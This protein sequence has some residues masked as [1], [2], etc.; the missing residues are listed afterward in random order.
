MD[1]NKF[2]NSARKKA[3]HFLRDNEMLDRLLSDS[4]AKMEQ[5]N[6]GSTSPEKLLSYL[7]VL[8]RMIR[9]YANGSYKVIPW[10]SIVVLVAAVVYFVMP[11]DLIPDF[12]PVAGFVDDLGVLVWVFNSFQDEIQ[13]F[14]EWEA[15]KV[16]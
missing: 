11:L 3:L 5:L 14:L 13:D 12:I 10:K 4:K 16:S 9:S 6:L 8:I 2:F 15:A 7:G 1:D